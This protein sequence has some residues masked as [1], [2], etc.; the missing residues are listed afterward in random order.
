MSSTFLSAQMASSGMCHKKG[1]QVGPVVG[2]DGKKKTDLNLDEFRRKT[3][4]DILQ[5]DEERRD[6]TVPVRVTYEV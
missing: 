2:D 3:Y 5:L 4:E 1:V 6:D